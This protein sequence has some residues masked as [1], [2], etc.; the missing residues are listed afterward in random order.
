MKAKPRILCVDDEQNV[1]DS[2]RR[3]L[4][5]NF[6]LN[7]AISGADGLKL[8]E[9]NGP[10][11]VVVSDFKMPGMNGVE[12]LKK[13]RELAPDTI[14]VMLTGQAEEK[15]AA[16]AINDGCIFRFLYKPITSSEFMKCLD[17]AITQ[18]NLVFAERDVLENTLKGSI[19]M[20]TD[21]L[22]LTNPIAFSQ[23]TRVQ[24][25]AQQL[26]T[27]LGLEDLWQLEVASILS[28]LGYVT[29]PKETLEKKGNGKTLDPHETQMFEDIPMVSEKLIGHIPRLENIVQ[30]ITKSHKEPSFGT[31]SM[32]DTIMVSA[33]I[34]RTVTRFNELI[35][36]GYGKMEAINEMALYPTRYNQSVIDQ[37]KSI[38]IQTYDIQ[39]KRVSINQIRVGMVLNEPI[40]TTEGLTVAPK[41]FVVNDLIRQLLKNLHLQDTI[42]EM[43]EV[44]INNTKEK[45]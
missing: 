29:I 22:S 13:A 41:G 36:K 8:M 23:A 43:V 16:E 21:I 26:G 7:T 2:F 32:N 6:D 40:K 42:P 28:F 3:L 10:F 17:Q 27:N 14:R 24:G 45:D 38:K 12:F 5:K 9:Q 37:V 33:A 25:Y 4:R 15:T 11:A 31:I 35:E 18:Y 44:V 19:E 1:L 30:I 39:S 34:L 20:M